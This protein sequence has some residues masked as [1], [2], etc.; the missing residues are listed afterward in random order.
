MD[1]IKEFSVHI[2]GVTPFIMNC[3]KGCDP[4]D[5]I[6]KKK[7]EI[8]GVK[9]KTDEHHLLMARLDWE[10]SLYYHHSI[11]V[12]LSSKT[13]MGCLKAAARKTKQGKL[14][15]AVLFDFA[16]GTPISGFEKTTPEQLWK[17][18]DKNGDQLHSFRDCVTIDNKKIMKVRPIFAKWD[19]KFNLGLD[20]TLLSAN[21]LK[22]IIST[23]G[24]EFGIGDMRPEKAAG[25]YGK[26]KLE[27]FKEI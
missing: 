19:V 2:K 18:V 10:Q 25:Q 3:D 7:K 21:D 14:M 27:D 8:S 4:L 12:F 22:R 13:L 6:T 20:T 11:G 26:F 16:M 5:P 9:S 17:M 24:A 23:A 1:Y 15:K